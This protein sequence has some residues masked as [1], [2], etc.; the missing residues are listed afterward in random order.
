MFSIVCPTYNHADY[1]RQCIQSVLAQTYD[2]W[3]LLIL[4]DGSNDGTG[5]KITPFL[6]DERIK[7]F[8]QEN[9][10][11]NRLAENY[12]FLLAKAKG[13]YVTIL[14][15]DDYAEPELLA[16]HY[17]L[18]K[19]NP[20]AVL[21]FNRVRVADP[22]HEWES[23]KVPVT[24]M[25]KQIFSNSPV[26]FALNEL[27]LGCFI[28]AQGV[29]LKRDTLVRSGGFEKVEGLATVDYPTW[30]KLVSLGTFVFVPETL[31]TW[32]R[33]VAQ[34]TKQR[35]VPLTQL[36]LPVY[37]R[38]YDELT[39]EVLKHVFISKKKVVRHWAIK[40][41]K[42]IIRGGNY[43]LQSRHWKEGRK[44]YFQSFRRWPSLLLLWRMK[45]ILGIIFSLMH[46]PW[47]HWY[48]FV[49]ERI[50]KLF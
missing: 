9:K 16:S 19:Q 34:S 1:I 21:S 31:A 28:P 3:E 36:M 25:Q 30:L 48:S 33:H 8:H 12:N 27:F 49:P 24:E 14:E 42:I 11:A 35:I 13:N 39:P 26:G 45:A 22:G 43:Q 40:F 41:T 2:N 4:D 5:E 47:M 23:P 50:A 10:G 44:L 38:V 15:G 32:R 6:S 20:K 29:T 46:I 7:Y 18:L 37:E 17:K